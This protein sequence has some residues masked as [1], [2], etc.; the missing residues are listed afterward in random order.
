M[1]CKKKVIK[2]VDLELRSTMIFRLSQYCCTVVD[3]AESQ[4]IEKKNFSKILF[5]SCSGLRNDHIKE[6]FELQHELDGKMFPCQFIKIGEFEQPS[7]I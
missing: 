7:S 1:L 4:K 2:A 6:A 3:R 5:V